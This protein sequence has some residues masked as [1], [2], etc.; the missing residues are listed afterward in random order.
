MRV[1]VRVRVS[2]ER[3]GR[4]RPLMSLV[5]IRVTGTAKRRHGTAKRRHVTGTGKRRR[6]RRADKR[7]RADTRG[8]GGQGGRQ[9]GLETTP[10][11]SV[12]SAN[13]VAS[14]AA[15]EM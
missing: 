13:V 8:E 15:A 4:V 1:R 3:A 10:L 11:Q 14:I 12:T 6:G 7:R 5:T 9:G 2:G